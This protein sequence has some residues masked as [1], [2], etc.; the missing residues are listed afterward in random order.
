MAVN[1]AKTTGAEIEV[2]HV[3]Y[4]PQDYWGYTVTYGITISSEDLIENGKAAIEASL[5]G[6]DTGDVAISKK[7]EGGHPATVIADVARKGSFD[8]II[9]GSHGYG[10]LAG[11]VLGSVSQRVL[12]K[13]EC[14]VMIVK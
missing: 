4:S 1:L 12:H 3:A 8:L 11:P 6:L 13:A 10:P 9:M 5:N 7:V 2:L 14:T